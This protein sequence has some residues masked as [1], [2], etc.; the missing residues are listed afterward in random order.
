MFQAIQYPQ[1]IQSPNSGAHDRFQETNW[2]F[3]NIVEVL[4]NNRAL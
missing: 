1:G 3:K 4:D 2:F